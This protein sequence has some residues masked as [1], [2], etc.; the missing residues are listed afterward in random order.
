M[1]LKSFI[2]IN[3]ILLQ[4]LVVRGSE[5]L[6]TKYFSMKLDKGCVVEM[7]SNLDGK[8]Y[9]SKEESTPLLQ[10]RLFSDPANEIKNYSPTGMKWLVPAKLLQLD[11]ADIAV[12]VVV[13]V[14]VKSSHIKFE[15]VKVTPA[16]KVELVLWG[17][18]FEALLV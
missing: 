4:M 5:L 11:F 18:L 10:V 8:D 14:S 12:T 17:F 3:F 9:L 1:K 15:T 7:K 13:E 16:K 2:I 6:K